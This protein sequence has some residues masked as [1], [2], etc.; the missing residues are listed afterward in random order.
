MWRGERMKPAEDDVWDNAREPIAQTFRSRGEVFTI[1]ANHLKS[2]GSSCGKTSDDTSVGGAGNCN[3]DRVAQ[4]EALVAFAHQVAQDAGD[5][6]VL[7]TGDYNS[8]RQEDPIDVI[9]SNGFQEVW[10][11]GEYS[12]VFGG[13]SG[14]LDHVFATPSMLA[15]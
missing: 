4:A 2:K 13:A 15:K 1:I 12:Y 7:M 10:T 6:D 8:Y 11:P 5:P 9:T 3:A 14:S